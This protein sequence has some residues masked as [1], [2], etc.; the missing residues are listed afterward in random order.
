MTRP[1]VSEKIKVMK[2]YPWKFRDSP[3]IV[4]F[5]KENWDSLW[6]FVQDVDVED[7]IAVKVDWMFRYAFEALPEHLGW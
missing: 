4:E 1:E 2:F 3:M 6:Q 5:T 7:G